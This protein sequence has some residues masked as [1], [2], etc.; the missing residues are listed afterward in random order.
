MTSVCHLQ[1]SVWHSW[2][3][4]EVLKLSESFTVFTWLPQTWTFSPLWNVSRGWKLIQHSIPRITREHPSGKIW[5]K[6]CQQD[7]INKISKPKSQSPVSEK[8]VFS[9]N[10]STKATPQGDKKGTYNIKKAKQTAAGPIWLLVNFP[11]WHSSG[12]CRFIHDQ[13]GNLR[14]IF[15]GN[16]PEFPSGTRRPMKETVDKFTVADFFGF[17]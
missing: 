5:R 2:F 17:I 3:L 9:K 12:L 16:S 11:P 15:W 4:L 13:S 1:W 8:K 14:A 7:L 6:T 10:C